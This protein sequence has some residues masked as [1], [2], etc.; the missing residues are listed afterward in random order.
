[1]EMRF[2]WTTP[3]STLRPETKARLYGNAI[4]KTAPAGPLWEAILQLETEAGLYGNVIFK[5][6]LLDHSGK[7]SCS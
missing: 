4:L 3:E 7:L 2:S 6:L 1:M 5:Q